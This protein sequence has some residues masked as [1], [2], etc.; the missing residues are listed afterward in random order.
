MHQK[1][2]KYL[3]FKPDLSQYLFQNIIWGIGEK[4]QYIGKY[5]Y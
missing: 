5:F 1:Y 3:G 2:D 4:S